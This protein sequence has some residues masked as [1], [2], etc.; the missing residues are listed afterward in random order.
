MP[1]PGEHRSTSIGENLRLREI[2]PS[3]AAQ[4]ARLCEELGYPVT[5]QQMQERLTRLRN[6]PDHVVYV[7]CMGDRVIAWIDVGIAQHLQTEPYG[8]IGGLVVSSDYRSRGIGQLLL[9]HA[10]RWIR[11]RGITRVVVRSRITRESAHRFYLREG[12]SQTKTSAVFAK[13]LG[14]VPSPE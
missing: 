1:A 14:N 8:E 7:A 3:D 11:A 9:A 2:A 6:T 12:Y 10:E 13:Q 5:E 4:A